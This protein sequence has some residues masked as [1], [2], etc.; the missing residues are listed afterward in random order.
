MIDLE[1]DRAVQG[2]HPP[3]ARVEPGAEDDELRGTLALDDVVD[4]S[5]AEEQVIDEPQRCRADDARAT[6]SLQRDRN[7]PGHEALCDG[8]HFRHGARGGDDPRGRAGGSLPHEPCVARPYE[9]MHV[10][11]IDTEVFSMATRMRPYGEGEDGPVR[12]RTYES[13][14]QQGYA[15]PDHIADPNE[16]KRGVQRVELGQKV[17]LPDEQPVEAVVEKDGA[18]RLAKRLRTQRK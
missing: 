10:A 9:G 13:F 18:R 2:I 8:I 7:R 17:K 14:G 11:S 16:V 1:H 6:H 12:D 4:A 5:R 3:C 15:M